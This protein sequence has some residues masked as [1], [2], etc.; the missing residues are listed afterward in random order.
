MARDLAVA[1]V[2]SGV[3]VVALQWWRWTG[4]VALARWPAPPWRCSPRSAARSRCSSG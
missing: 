2:V 4:F 1:E 3:V